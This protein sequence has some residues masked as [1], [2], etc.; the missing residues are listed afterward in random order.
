[1]WEVCQ[2]EFNI[3][4]YTFLFE[5]TIPQLTMLIQARLERDDAQDEKNKNKKPTGTMDDMNEIMRGF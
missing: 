4:L 3:S 5:Y 2:S 1:M